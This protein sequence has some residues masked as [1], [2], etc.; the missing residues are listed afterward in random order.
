[1][2]CHR[3][4]LEEV[5]YVFTSPVVRCPSVQEVPQ[6]PP[7]AIRHALGAAVLALGLLTAPPRF[8]AAQAGT[9][10]SA[11]WGTD[12]EEWT[13]T[14]RLPD[15]SYAGY[16]MGETALPQVPVWKN[17]KTDYGAKGD[18]KSTRL[19]SSHSRASRMP[20]SA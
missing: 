20:S 11:L 8:V 14:S 12:G 19:N 3:H 16:H 13:P 2:L 1:M 9:D 18:R 10:T 7:R 15:F 5:P 4:I 6:D 17:L